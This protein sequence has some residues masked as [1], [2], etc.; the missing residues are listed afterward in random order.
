MSGVEPP[1]WA[2]GPFWTRVAGTD[3]VVGSE[4]AA[5]TVG[6]DEPPLRVNYHALHLGQQCQLHEA[7]AS[8]SEVIG[9]EFGLKSSAVWTP[10][11]EWMDAVFRAFFPPLCPFPGWWSVLSARRPA[12]FRQEQDSGVRIDQFPA[13]AYPLRRA[14]VLERKGPLNFGDL[15]IPVAGLRLGVHP[16]AEPKKTR[17][18]MTVVPRLV[19]AP[20]LGLRA[21]Y[22]EAWLCLA[23]PVA[24]AG[25]LA[26]GQV[27]AI[28]PSAYS[29]SAVRVRETRLL[30][31]V[32]VGGDRWSTTLAIELEPASAEVLSIRR[33]RMP[34]AAALMGS[35]PVER[36]GLEAAAKELRA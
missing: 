23:D 8:A 22:D 33:I 3:E 9:T 10:Q 25:R 12:Q 17:L 13:R 18:V 31:L 19:E 5:L 26:A 21:H 27:P 20:R 2:G 16:D 32:R 30:N 24:D 11:Q 1:G 14:A 4:Q 29:G 28:P 34:V 6:P 35:S 7:G 15:R 36:V